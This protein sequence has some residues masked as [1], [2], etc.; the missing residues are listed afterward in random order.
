M[1]DSVKRP[2]RKILVV[3]DS[4]TQAEYLR[5]VLEDDGYRVVLATNGSDALEQIAIDRPTIVLTD[6]VMPEMDGYELCRR[7][8]QNPKISS[9]PVVLVT[10]LF[11]PV[12]VIKGLAAGAD[13]FIIK[14]FEP[15][16]IR[17]RI[18]TILSAAGSPDPDA[19]GS[20]LEVSF[21]QTTHL[22]GSSRR[23][24]LNILLSTYEVAV[25]KNTELMEA[26]ER[27][28]A[29]NE[30]LQ[31]AVSGLKRLNTD[32]EQ[33][34]TERRRVEK[35]L[36]DANKK[37]NLMASITRHDVL[38]QLT[39]QH[40]YL[41]SS[42][43]QR[44][45]ASDAAW[46][47]VSRA[48]TIA[49]QTINAIRFTGDYQKI[50]VKAPVWQDVRTLVADATATVPTGAITVA[51]DLPPDLEVYADPL[52]GSIFINLI[53]N[54]VKYG[55]TITSIRFSAEDTGENTIITCQDN[56]VGVPPANKE[57]I[58]SYQ[59]GMNSSMGL[60]L[61]R[62]ILALTGIMI[63]ETG[64]YRDGACFQITCPKATV[65]RQ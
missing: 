31:E 63:R 32:L 39:T 44:E 26:Q 22:V 19:P 55:S 23:Q 25:S 21:A 46:A 6:I 5:H 34:N 45:R 60:F 18:S 40:E 16:Y 62:E 57:K 49:E 12:D 36:D 52:I 2:V 56:G 51:N 58:F 8:K 47:N 3:E 14:P 17:A 65:R 48:K 33:E 1:A 4:R 50:G 15:A 54:A 10:Q 53:E 35:A 38:N 28:S 13:D 41:E 7:I 24:I 30:Q 20:A 64:S 37:L 42:L 9:L 27:L 43:A 11:D 29:L 59:Y 61:A